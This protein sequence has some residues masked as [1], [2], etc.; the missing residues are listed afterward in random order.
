MNLETIS[1]LSGKPLYRQSRIPQN[2]QLASH[3]RLFHYV[4]GFNH[5]MIISMRQC[6][7]PFAIVSHIMTLLLVVIT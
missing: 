5:Q 4:D 1:W 6:H 3:L 7:S 2:Y